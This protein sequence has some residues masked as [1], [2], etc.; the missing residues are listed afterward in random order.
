MQRTNNQLE[1][2]YLLLSKNPIAAGFQI[3][4]RMLLFQL[5]FVLAIFVPIWLVAL[6]VGTGSSDQPEQ[7]AP[8]ASPYSQ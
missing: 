7:S 3:W 8:P 5:I 4:W 1:K 6:V 2:E